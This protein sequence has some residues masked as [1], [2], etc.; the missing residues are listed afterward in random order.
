VPGGIIHEDDLVYAGH[1]L[2][3]DLIDVYLGHVVVEPR[4]HVTGLGE[5]T[6]KEAASLGLL[7][8]DVGR[9]L[10]TI[11]RAEHV[12]SFVLGDWVPHLHF[13]VVPRYSGTPREYWGVRVSEWPDAPRGG[14]DDITAVCDRLRRALSTT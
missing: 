1:I 13:H 11:E 7:V 10:K 6:D 12:Y 4:R 2:P 8:N 9:A 5:L 14:A 3:P